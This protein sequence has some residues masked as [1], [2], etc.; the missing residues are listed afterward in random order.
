MFIAAPIL[1]GWASGYL[2]IRSTYDVQVYSRYNDVYEEEN[3]PQNSYEIITD[4]LTEHKI[5]TDYD[6]TFN[7]YLPEK[8]DVHNRQKH[9]FPIVSISLSDYN[10]VRGLLGYEQISLEADQFTIQSKAIATEEDR[11]NF[12]KEH[13]SIMTDAGELTLSGQSYYEDPIGETAYNSRKS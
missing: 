6:C 1:T 5:D 12:L 8:V 4:F 10:T 13:T 9:D 2:D 3:L 7:L 11:D